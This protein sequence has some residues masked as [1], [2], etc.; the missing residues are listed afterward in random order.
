M[1]DRPPATPGAPYVTDLREEE[2][3]KK[4]IEVVADNYSSLLARQRA[5]VTD[6]L[7]SAVRRL[8]WSADRLVADRQRRLREMLSFAA[9]HSKF[10]AERL[11]GVDLDSFTEADLPSLPIM[12]KADLM[13]N[14]DRITTDPDLSLELVSAH[15]DKLKDDEYLLDKYR[16]VAT[17][18]TTGVRAL[19][20]YGWD[21]WVNLVLIVTRWR[22]RDGDSLP[23][24][25]PV[26]SLFAL[27]AKYLSG[28]LHAF[29]RGMS[30]GGAP[31]VTHLPATLPLPQIVAGLN[32]AQ[33][34]VLQ[35]Y[36]S[37][38]HLLAREAVAGRLVITPKRVA[39]C[40]E[41]LT[42]EVRAVVAQAWGVDVYD[43]WGCSEGVYA[44]PCAAGAAM[45][46]PDD[47]VIL[48]PVDRD[49]NVVAPGQPAAKVLLT[50]L[51]NLT[52]PLVRY[53]ITDGMTVVPGICECGC[54]HRRITGLA[55][56]T[57]TLFVYG[58][59]VAV[60][61][62]GMS[63]VFLSD[64]DVVEFQ[65]TQTPFGADV[66]VVTNKPCDSGALT[67]RLVE[68]MTNAGL[69]APVVTVC[70]IASLDRLFSGKLRRFQPL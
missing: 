2:I 26:G 49:G 23:L 60:N 20:V 9:E 24:E 54:A 6:K 30:G 3:E 21:D 4:E 19:F 39:T 56:R 1:T 65:V 50:N 64:P 33:P 34:L 53:E 63:G 41:Q 67:D 68:L 44:F 7:F 10:H 5:E 46:L 12:T 16:V 58:E 14:F 37:A 22:G 45:H 18:G 28:A 11:A 48:E 70:E 27:D 38:V 61:Q 31:L 8:G 43:Y 59:G 36:P 55:G 35:G 15:V 52:Q 57:D 66:F 29:S 51:Y 40:G 42:A 69:S 17:S 32:L 25:A 47:L 13:E 62:L